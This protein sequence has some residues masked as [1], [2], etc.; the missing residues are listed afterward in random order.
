MLDEDVYPR[1]KLGRGLPYAIS[2]TLHYTILLSGFLLG[3]A[4]LGFDMTKFTILAGAFTV[5]VGFG[6]QNIFNNF[7]SGLILLFER[8]VQVGDVIQMD[9]IAG[10]VDRIG[11]RASVVRANNGSEIIVP[12]GKL[13]SERLINWT[14]SSRRRGIELDVAVAH[15]A[16]PKRVIELMNAAAVAH[17]RVEKSPPPQ[18]LLMRMGPDWLGFELRAFTERIEDWVNIRSDLSIAINDALAA[19]HIA[20]K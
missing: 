9:D 13:I 2:R 20:L 19:E 18:T 16:D 17:P 10:T 14:F 6:L 3:V 4:A 1:A 12:N 7:V 15:G 5:G 8:P 11:I